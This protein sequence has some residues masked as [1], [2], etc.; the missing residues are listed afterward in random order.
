M[1]GEDVEMSL[2]TQCGAE[3]EASVQTFT[4]YVPN[5]DRDG[6][7][8][9]SNCEEDNRSRQRKTHL[10]HWLRSAQC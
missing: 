8:R 9:L 5:K 4:V 2:A 10:R 7:V 6:R 3:E 1:P